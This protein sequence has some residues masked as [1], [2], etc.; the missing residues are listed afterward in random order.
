MLGFSCDITMRLK[1]GTLVE[2]ELDP[3]SLYDTL[4]DGPLGIM[5]IELAVLLSTLNC[6]RGTGGKWYYSEIS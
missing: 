5:I 1:Y 4:P 3:Y 2:L 6:R